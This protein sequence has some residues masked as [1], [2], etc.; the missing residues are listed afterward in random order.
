[1]YTYCN[2]ILSEQTFLM[3]DLQCKS[4][5]MVLL[6][7][8]AKLNMAAYGLHLVSVNQNVGNCLKLF[9]LEGSCESK[10]KKTWRK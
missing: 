7:W 3:G 2:E 8:T 1:M 4:L 9:Y 10:G 5:G 6:L